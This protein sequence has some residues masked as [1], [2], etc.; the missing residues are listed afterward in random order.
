VSVGLEIGFEQRQSST[1]ET[2][3]S[4]AISYSKT[5]TLAYPSTVSSIFVM[6]SDLCV[7]MFLDEKFS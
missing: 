5:V 4:K 7:C 2:G 1:K 6:G 3:W